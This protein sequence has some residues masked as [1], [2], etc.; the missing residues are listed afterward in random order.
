MAGKTGRSYYAKIEGTL[1]PMQT[2]IAPVSTRSFHLSTS[3]ALTIVLLAIVFFG[4]IR[5]RLRDMPLERDEGE[6]AYSGQLMLQ[7]IPPYKLAYNMKLPGIYAAYAGI[8]AVFGQTSSAIHLGLIFVNAA[9]V[10]LLYVLTALLFGRFAAVIAA[11]SYALLSTTTSVMGFEAHATNFVVPPALLAIIVLVVALR[12]DR[13]WLLFLSGLSAGIAVVMK[14]H[15]L[16]FAAF[17]VYLLFEERR[18]SVAM[19]RRIAI[20]L[21]GVIL[22][23]ALTCWSLWRAGVFS[24]LWFWTVS[25]AGEYS[26]MGLHRALRAFFENFSDVVHPAIPLWILATVGFS[27]FWWDRSARR[28]RG[29][30]AGFLFFSFLSICP[31]AYFRPHYFVLLLPVT[32][33]LVGVAINSGRD[34][35]A[36]RSEFARYAFLPALIFILFFGNGIFLQ[37][38]T[39]FSLSP[40]Q[41]FAS[42]YGADN[43][44]VP[45]VEIGQYLKSH[46]ASDAQVA[47]LGSEP[48]IYFYAQRHSATGYLYM[49]SLI[50]RHKYTAQMQ[51]EM[52]HEV[53]M[54]RPQFLV[55]VDF[56]DSWGE[57]KGMPQAAVFLD[58]LQK[59]REE[60][61]QQVG[62]AESARDSADQKTPGTDQITYIWGKTAS[63][64]VP[65]SENAIYVLERK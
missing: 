23:Y 53:E 8:L 63:S 19:V 9:A 60:N 65:R 62:V 49:Y 5:Y 28:N 17:C 38:Q 37:R 57:R 44:F 24:R 56:F 27:A 26:K 39:Y 12:S 33:M 35:L 25:Y 7:G 3:T 58:R 48:E 40:R 6:Y 20:F 45:A 42:R 55:Y 1:L 11:C 16:F 54:N 22:P 29:F 21:A 10:L 18:R 4:A 13:S 15:A 32:A 41:V 30:V 47:V 36:H 31:G 50:V 61:Y 52:L 59:F 43:P 64:Y 34:S 14:Q 2:A 51:S 46:T